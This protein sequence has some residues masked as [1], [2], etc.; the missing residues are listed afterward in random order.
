MAIN[1]I[2]SY[3]MGYYNY[4]ASINNMRLTQALANNSRLTRS[5]FS[6]ASSGNNSLKS[7][8]NFIK[9]YSSSRS[10]ERRVGKEC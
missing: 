5:A 6:S 4:Q 2:N 8:V 9:D 10:E 1:G 3:G 7:S